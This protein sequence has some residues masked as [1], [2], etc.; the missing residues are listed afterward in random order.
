MKLIK[1]EMVLSIDETIPSGTNVKWIA[2]S[3][4]DM[5]EGDEVIVSFESKEVEND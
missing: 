4:G 1:V 5:L 2:E 3:I